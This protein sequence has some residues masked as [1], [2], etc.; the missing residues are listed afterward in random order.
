MVAPAVVRGAT[1]VACLISSSLAAGAPA[2]SSPAGIGDAGQQARPP[3]PRIRYSNTIEINLVAVDGEPTSLGI[4]AHQQ[5]GAPQHAAYPAIGVDYRAFQNFS[6]PAH[7]IQRATIAVT[8]PGLGTVPEILDAL[9]IG[10]AQAPAPARR[11]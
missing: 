2:S 7:A 9:G 10:P 4:L 3:Q 1:I 6:V 11:F 5:A 8:L